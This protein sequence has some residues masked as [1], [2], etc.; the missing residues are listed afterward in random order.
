MKTVN[1][2]RAGSGERIAGPLWLAQS[3]W[4]RMKGLLGR[5]ELSPGRGMVIR[6]CYSVHTFFMK[7]PLDLVFT[8]RSLRVLKTR[9]GVRPFRMAFS[10]W[11][12]TVIELGPGSFERSPIRVGE[13][14]ELREAAGR[15][16]A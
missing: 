5:K 14:L 13:I 1:L 10:L 8:D 3:S 12:D 2:H 15:A 16:T 11:A 9:R 7:F 6:G 4:E